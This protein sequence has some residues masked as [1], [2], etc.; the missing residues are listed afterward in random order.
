MR[1]TL[2][3]T[4]TLMLGFMGAKADSGVPLPAAPGGPGGAAEL[5][6][7][8]DLSF[9]DDSSSNFPIRG[10]NLADGRIASD[11]PTAIF[12]GT[13]HCWNTNREAER[14]VALF[15]LY[16][17][18]V[19]FLVVDLD[20]PAREQKALVARFYGGSIPHLTFLDRNGRVV[21]NR[22]GE[23]ATGRGDVRGLEE[24][25]RKSLE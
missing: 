4:A 14:F 18:R 12:F 21:Y 10:K 6:L 16:Q 11:R 20:H 2:V 15:R 17:D 19:R 8:P 23:T 24:L 7:A 22:S 5:A 1:T 13:S 9:T 25:T 3:L